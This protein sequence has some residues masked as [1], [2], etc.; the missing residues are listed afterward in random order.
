MSRCFTCASSCAI[1]PRKLPRGQH[2]QHAPSSRR[3]PRARGRVRSRTRWAGL[4]RS[5]TRAASAAPRVRGELADHA[6]E[7]RRARRVDL[8]ARCTCAAPSC[9]RTSSAQRFVATPKPSASSMPCAPPSAAPTAPNSATIAAISIPV[10]TQLPKFMVASPLPGPVTSPATLPAPLDAGRAWG[11][12][13]SRCRRDEPSPAATKRPAA[14]AR[15]G[16]RLPPARLHAR[17]AQRAVA[18][19]DV[20]A[21][22]RA[23]PA[24]FPAARSTAVG[25]RF[26]GPDLDRFR[27]PTASWAPGQRDR[28]PGPPID[29]ACA[30]RVQS[31]PGVARGRCLAA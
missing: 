29:G 12:N 2:A 26:G 13:A 30:S 3:P 1:T 21:C 10:L 23:R 19:G 5:G 28:T 7:L 25:G 8:A 14:N 9:R 6:V 27:P 31:M 20:D 24:R 18:A 17:D 11:F 15:A 4:R 16:I 22:R